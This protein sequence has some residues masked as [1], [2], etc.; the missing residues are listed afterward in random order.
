MRPARVAAL[1][2]AGLPE[3]AVAVVT[4]P[5]EASGSDEYV[6][7]ST[8][9]VTSMREFLLK[10]RDF[11]RLRQ[12]RPWGIGNVVQHPVAVGES[13]ERPGQLRIERRWPDA[14]A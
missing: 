12:L 10:R 1:A 9:R 6:A 14:D 4:C 5:S 8:S 7:A 13:R 2:R 11:D 3:A